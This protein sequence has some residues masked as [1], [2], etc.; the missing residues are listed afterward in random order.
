MTVLFYVLLN[1][2]NSPV[3]KRDFSGACDG[4]NRKKLE[5]LKTD[6]YP[7]GE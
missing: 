4:P 2:K 3:R 7:F 1:D 6:S 5:G